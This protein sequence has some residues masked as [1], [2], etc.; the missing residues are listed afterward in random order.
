MGTDERDITHNK[1]LVVEQYVRSAIQ[2]GLF[3]HDERLPSI[4]RLQQELSVSKN[5]VIRAYQEL[6]AQGWVYSVERSGYRV[7]PVAIAP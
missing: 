1:Y 6:E 7:K 2:S 4:R 3:Q 5:T